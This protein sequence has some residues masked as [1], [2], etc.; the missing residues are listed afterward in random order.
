M[1]P[2]SIFGSAV[3]SKISPVS[4]LS[5]LFD[6][7]PFGFG[8]NNVD[9]SRFR[10]DLGKPLD[11]SNDGLHSSH[12][13]FSTKEAIGTFTCVEAVNKFGFVYTAE[14]SDTSLQPILLTAHQDFVLVERETL[15]SW[16]HPPVDA[17]YNEATGYL[18]GR[19]ASDDKSAITALMSA[20]EALLTQEDY[21]PRRTV[22]LAFGFDKECSGL[23]GASSI[24]KHLEGRYGENEIAIILDEGGAGLQSV[25]D[26]LYALPAVYEKGYLDVWFDIDVVGWHSSTPTP[27]TSIGVLSEIVVALESNPPHLLHTLLTLR[28]AGITLYVN[29]GLLNQAAHLLAQVQRERQYFIQTS[30]AVDWIAGGQKINSLPEFTT[31]GVNHRYAPQDSIGSIQ[32]RIV[33]LVQ[34]VANKYNLTVQAFECDKDYES[35][36]RSVGHMPAVKDRMHT[37]WEPIFN[38]KLTLEAKKRSYIIPQAPTHGTAK[39]I[40]PAPGAMTGNNDTRRF[41]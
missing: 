18:Y 26:V 37:A 20:M 27:H 10:C 28:S 39:T 29:L 21:N 14:G 8:H 25:G 41:I 38:R 12:E 7:L 1:L 22:I 33:N 16:E 30:Q 9:V 40:I 6:Q 36:L 13:L 34:G 31:Q 24:S 5:K 35:Y 19:G 11:P 23:R 32:D 17:Y 4:S 15:D 3:A 2:A